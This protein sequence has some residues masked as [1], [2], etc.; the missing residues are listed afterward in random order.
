LGW[1]FNV[2][3]IPLLLR[4]VFQ[5]KE[6]QKQYIQQSSLERLIVRPPP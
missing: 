5:N 1:V 2:F 6:V 4:N 3:I